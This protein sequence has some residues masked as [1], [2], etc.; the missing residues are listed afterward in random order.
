MHV[1]HDTDP[2]LSIIVPVHQMA[3]KLEKLRSWIDIAAQRGI[4]V[5][6]VHDHGDLLTGDELKSIIKIIASKRILFLEGRY[7]GPGA[8]RNAGKRI[9]TGKFLNFTDSDD[10][11]E[12]LELLR[13]CSELI[14]NGK[15]VCIGG[16][17]V[18]SSN[19][20]QNS[21]TISGSAFWHVNR[22]KLIFQPGIWRFVILREAVREL[23]FGGEKMGE[24]QYF[25]SQLSLGKD[26][27]CFSK[28]ICYAYFTGHESQ[29]TKETNRFESLRRT[30]REMAILPKIQKSQLGVFLLL[31]MELTL[32]IRLKSRS[33]LSEILEVNRKIRVQKSQYLLFIYYYV[34]GLILFKSSRLISNVR[35]SEY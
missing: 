19:E 8:A 31:R 4:E 6:I 35:S 17:T 32:L 33:Q 23:S 7:Q 29:L 28:N 18:V 5:I 25:I 16:Y 2:L 11:P 27:V 14:E 15:S 20:L 10:L 34:C 12:T 3:G 30:L 13:M 21:T 1:P 9:A 22:I 24:D 26:Q